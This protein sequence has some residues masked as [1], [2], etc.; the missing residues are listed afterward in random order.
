MKNSNIKKC[1]II[2]L[3]FI[4]ILGIFY[5]SALFEKS[6]F[7][8]DQDKNK[9][10]ISNHFPLKSKDWIIENSSIINQTTKIV[11]ESII[12]Q[13]NGNLTINWNGIL[14]LNS[15]K[16]YEFN[17]TVKDNGKLI[18]NNGSID[19]LNK[20][21]IF[22]QDN[23]SLITSNCSTITLAEI[24]SSSNSTLNISDSKFLLEEI[25][26][27][28]KKF[29]LNNSFVN[30]TYDG[31]SS[32]RTLIVSQEDI[33]IN[34]SKICSLGNLLGTD[35]LPSN[36][37]LVTSNNISIINS[38]L[39]IIGGAG[40]GG[41]APA[42]GN[43]YVNLIGNH[44][45]IKNISLNSTGKEVNGRGSSSQV[46]INATNTFKGS[47]SSFFLIGMTS[48]NF[49]HSGNSELYLI[50][51]NMNLDHFN[52]TAKGG[53]NTINNLQGG[54]AN[55]TILASNIVDFNDVN[56]LVVGGNGLPTFNPSD[57]GNVQ[58]MMQ[59]NQ[60]LLNDS[61]INCTAGLR[62]LITSNNG[63]VM[64][65]LIG[66][67]TISNM[68]NTDVLINNS[69]D[70]DLDGLY[71]LFELS[72]SNTDPILN[73]TD[74]D[75]LNDNIEYSF[76]LTNPLNNDTDDDGLDDYEELVIY[77]T[78]PLRKDTDGDNINDYE[79]VK[80]WKTNPLSQDS[81][82]DGL[83]DFDEIFLY[84]TDPNDIDT[85]NDGLIDLIDFFK[86]I[87]I[88]I[89]IFITIIASSSSVILL[90]SRNLKRKRKLFQ[91]NLKNYKTNLNNYQLIF[92]KYLENLE[93]LKK[94]LIKIS[95]N[96]V[97][98]SHDDENLIGEYKKFK[99]FI[100]IPEIIIDIDV[101]LEKM[102]TYLRELNKKYRKVGFKKD[103]ES[104]RI[105]LQENF[106]K[107]ELRI[108]FFLKNLRE[109][110]LKAFNLS[111]QG[112]T[113]EDN[114]EFQIHEFNSHYEKFVTFFEKK[115]TEI[116]KN[117]DE[118]LSRNNLGKI[119]EEVKK[120]DLSFSE[121]EIWFQNA[122]NWANELKIPKGYGFHL[123][124]SDKWSIYSQ[125]RDEFKAKIYALNE[126]IEK[127]IRL[128]RDF[129]SWNIVLINDNKNK[130]DK[131]IRQ[132][133]F[134]QLK[135]LEA[136][137]LDIDDILKINIDNLK[138]VIVNENK[139]MQEFFNLHDSY[140]IED[141]IVEWHDSYEEFIKILKNIRNEIK[142]NYMYL[143]RFIKISKALF[144][145]VEKRVERALKK[146]KRYVELNRNQKDFK[147]I[148]EFINHKSNQ[149][150]SYIKEFEKYYINLCNN[151]PF[152]LSDISISFFIFDWEE[153]KEKIE[154]V[155]KRFISQKF[156]FKCDIMQEYLDPYK[157]EI[158]ECSNCGA[159]A[160]NEHLEKWFIK[161]GTP[162]CFKC[163]S[164]GSFAKK[165]IEGLPIN[166]E[167]KKTV[168]KEWLEL[169]S[170][171]TCGKRLKILSFKLLNNKDL[172]I[173]TSC[174]DHL[175]IKNFIL[176][177][178]LSSEWIDL[179][180][181]SI[182]EEIRGIFNKIKNNFY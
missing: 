35:G 120:L 132:K 41:G 15:S 73:D 22:L 53:N 77:G 9:F 171:K 151:L 145:H 179:I 10:P 141:L 180:E 84:H 147:S 8:S 143:S 131:D 166:L 25:K 34:N 72:E 21:K 134:A 139:K 90:R 70:F 31:T 1:L 116:N 103:L 7:S 100:G 105:K 176:P 68:S 128:I 174:E 39:D 80:I 93:E 88:D 108:A 109:V 144:N 60:I 30:V 118:W 89:P 124:L 137:Q 47:D 172:E 158:W 5:F 99:N 57:G 63:N 135:K 127:S 76:Y 27:Y 83:S 3:S 45:L 97:Y 104:Y 115:Y 164:I 149:I 92:D 96:Y 150:K 26:I 11:N 117:L 50:T 4:I 2:L 122:S 160:C 91:S 178:D 86:L 114:I 56:V 167:A 36:F 106:E 133:I 29:I 157:S 75:L 111:N 59:A 159:I 181:S 140:P 94:N 71:N 95:L 163:G 6:L 175:E 54:Q 40:G 162:Q 61:S 51:K 69:I 138:A 156:Q 55:V 153:H 44:I 110:F 82:G 155:L 24:N 112:E 177:R 19:S 20:S 148:N 13:G 87:P 52:I 107:K 62:D 152:Y 46:F 146:H 154:I 102:D 48:T 79:E 28:C 136:E 33:I 37:T 65:H 42:G 173:K 142:E 169:L 74:G 119:R 121:I 170:C 18:L 126:N 12:I 38:F 23:A 85:D 125:K 67:L 49:Q 165:K 130:L 129:I 17:I 43:S 182:N 161:K 113:K 32:S 64:F 168:K 78:N 14:Y 58:L 66:Q 123:Q 101:V 81:D 16:E 98:Q